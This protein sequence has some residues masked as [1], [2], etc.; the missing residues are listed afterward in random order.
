MRQWP[1]VGLFVLVSAC[2]M[3]DQ[4]PERV[5][6]VV[7]GDTLTRIANHHGV[8]VQELMTWNGLTSDRIEV[9]QSLILKGSQAPVAA[10][11]VPKPQPA[12]RKRVTKRRPKAKP[13]VQGPS[14]DDLDND[15]VDIRGSQGLEY[16]QLRTAMGSFPSLVGD[17]FEGP[18]P[19]AT[20]MT[21]IV[22]GCS[23]VVQHV[24]VL[25]GGGLEEGVLNCMSETL[26][27]VEFPAHD[28]PDGFTFQY[29]IQINP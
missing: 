7:R 5:H 12:K 18:W 23:G 26:R 8:T 6:V 20:V 9:G 22:V 4:E 28:M 29:P 11:D 14:L 3:M 16:Q 24:K 25:D 1:I 2:S 17:C 19:S 27:L 15:E 10:P 21:S 13:C